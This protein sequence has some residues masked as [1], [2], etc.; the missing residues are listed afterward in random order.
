MQFFHYRLFL[1][2]LFFLLQDLIFNGIQISMEFNT[3]DIKGIVSIFSLSIDSILSFL[4]YLLQ[5]LI[6]NG[7]Q[8]DFVYQRVY[9]NFF[10][11]CE[12]RSVNLMRGLLSGL[13]AK[14]IY[15]KRSTVSS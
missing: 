2:F 15:L 9:N 13:F 10:G 3:G 12:F 1:S 14:L 11:D 8:I 6:F 7:N 5:D 4:H